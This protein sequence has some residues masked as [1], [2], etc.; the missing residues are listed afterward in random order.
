MNESALPPLTLDCPK[1]HAAMHRRDYEVASAYRCSG[2]EGLW[3]PM[4]EFE[5]LREDADVVDVGAAETGERYNSI[6]R[7]QCPAC[8]HPSPMVRMV[9]AQQ[10]H[11]WFESCKFCYGRFYDAGE[12]RD[13]ADFTAEDFF[14][15]FKVKT[16]Y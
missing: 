7:I 2:C 10:P 4:L 15:R 16:R 1:C 3:F 6:D 11:I 14:K 13:F 8:N 5:L 9:D 12:F